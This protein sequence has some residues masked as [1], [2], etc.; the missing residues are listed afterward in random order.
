[1]FP[2]VNKRRRIEVIRKLIG[3]ENRYIRRARSHLI[4]MLTEG[5]YLVALILAKKI[6]N[7][8]VMQIPILKLYCPEGEI[9]VCVWIYWGINCSKIPPQS[10]SQLH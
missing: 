2:N 1:M 4:R 5:K 8:I 3:P 9:E 6:Y 7:K 10:F